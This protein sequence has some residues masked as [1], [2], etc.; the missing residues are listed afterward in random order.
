M[1]ENKEREVQNTDIFSD[2]DIKTLDTEVSY[3]QGRLK[4]IFCKIIFL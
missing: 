4:Y 1:F 3:L 2:E